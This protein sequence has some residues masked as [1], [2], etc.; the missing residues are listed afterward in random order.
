MKNQEKVLKQAA[1]MLLSMGEGDRKRPPR[2]NKKD[3]KRRFKAEVMDGR[4]VIKEVGS[5]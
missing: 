5:H 1:R 3:A 4:F 2:P